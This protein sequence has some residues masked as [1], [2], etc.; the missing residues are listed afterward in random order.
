ML[1]SSVWVATGSSEMEHVPCVTQQVKGYQQEDPEKKETISKLDLGC[2]HYLYMKKRLPVAS[3]DVACE[4]LRKGIHV[5][6]CSCY[7][8]L[9][10]L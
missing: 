6:S 2:V 10:I 3:P 8:C 5:R 7:F 4:S 1:K 9:Q